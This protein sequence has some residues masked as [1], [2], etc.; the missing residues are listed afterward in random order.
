MK[1]LYNIDDWTDASCMK[2]GEILIEAGKIN[3][4]HISMV[5]DI[6]KFK[7]LPMGQILLSMNVINEND[8]E[9]AL[10]IQKELQKRC[11]NN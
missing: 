11:N 4:Y 2:L 3:L 8:L 7:H 5:L 9:Q 6:Q 1:D 10:V